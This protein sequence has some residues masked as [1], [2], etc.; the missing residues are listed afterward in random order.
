M[1]F[2]KSAILIIM[3]VSTL[4][5]N[6][7]HKEQGIRLGDKAPDFTLKN[8]NGKE[9]NLYQLLEKG[10]V[11]LSWYRGGWCPYCNMELKGLADKATE[12]T[13]LGATLIALSPELPDKSLTTIEKNHLS[14]MVL[15]DT[16]NDVA[17]KYDLVFK[18]DAE[19]A[20]RY[21]SGFGLSQYNDN[22]KAELPIPAT[23]IIDKEGIVRYAFVNPDYKKRANPED[24]LMQLTQLVKAS[25]NNKL[26]LVW[27][28]DDPMV[29][30]RVA[31]M[32]PHT[33][34]KNKWFS[35]VILVIWGPSAKLIAEDVTLQKKISG[36]QA[37]GVKV[38]ACIACASAYGVADQLKTL[39]YDVLP[40]GEPLANYLKRGYHVI[41]F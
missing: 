10:P 9:V 32:F 28:S 15:S 37:D 14:F 17:R 41:T 20:T 5:G 25:N 36:M 22:D 12:I 3:V 24:I 23:Y 40:M 8:Q 39:R 11:V 38:E 1:K 26:V 4:A 33:A 13:Q 35:E 31:L 34:Q 27:S 7:Q 16:D 6:A 29:A 21:E 2:I 19:T 30:E 18:L